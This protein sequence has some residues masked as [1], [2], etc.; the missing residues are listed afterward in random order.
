MLHLDLAHHCNKR[1]I[2]A[3]D[4][5]MYHMLAFFF[6]WNS[7][8]A[9]SSYSSFG[10]VHCVQGC[11]GLNFLQLDENVY[12]CQSFVN[13]A[14]NVEACCSHCVRRFSDLWPCPRTSVITTGP[15]V[16]SDQSVSFIK[17][18]AVTAWQTMIWLV[19]GEWRTFLQN[20]HGFL[21]AQC[22]KK[23]T[24]HAQLLNSSKP[25]LVTV[26]ERLKRCTH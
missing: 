22:T 3:F 15:F 18:T 11:S 14:R 2:D 24:L 5:A 9:R 17:N 10:G 8:Y 4:I 19:S 6:S 21:G 20:I 25:N 26:P 16:N 23:L 7:D 1:V 12:H 13:G